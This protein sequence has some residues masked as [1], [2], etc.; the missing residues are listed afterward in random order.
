IGIVAYSPLV[1][2]DFIGNELGRSLVGFLVL[3]PLMWAGLQGNQR[4]VATAALI[5]C[6]IAVWGFSAGVGPFLKTDV[7]KALLSL[8][9]LAM[10]VSIP[11]LVLAAASATRKNTEAQLLHE[12][13]RL[14][15]QIQ[16]ANLA[17][18]SAKRHFQILIEG[19]VDYAIFVLDTAGRVAS[20]NNAA[21]K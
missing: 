8:F 14:N 15:R 13:E 2:S 12:R 1:G 17:R 3:L 18:D 16:E 11:P 5:F 19:V 6:G 7:N 9:V 21:Q 10:S 20:W 4:N